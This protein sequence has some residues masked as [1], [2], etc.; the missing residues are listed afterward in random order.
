MGRATRAQ[1]ALGRTCRTTPLSR[2]PHGRDQHAS[3][4]P[5]M[6]GAAP[7][8]NRAACCR[9]PASERVVGSRR[10]GDQDRR[11]VTMLLSDAAVSSVPGPDAGADRRSA[12]CR[13]AILP[14]RPAAAGRRRAASPLRIPAWRNGDGHPTPTAGHPLRSRLP[15]VGNRPMGRLHRALPNAARDPDQ[16]QQQDVPTAITRPEY[17]T[18][19]GVATRA[20]TGPPAARTSCRGA[21]RDLAG[22][23]RNGHRHPRCAR[24]RL[25]T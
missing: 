19:Y 15:A 22:R 5:G 21:S 13:V 6:A 23:Q 18:P 20:A 3:A 7:A 1:K 8:N 25:L 12:G 17:A 10:S 9:L 11:L 4:R 16:G 14:R 24:P 2:S